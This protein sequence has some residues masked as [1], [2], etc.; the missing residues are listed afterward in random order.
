MDP[1]NIKDRIVDFIRV[2]SSELSPHPLN[3]RTH[4]KSQASA[5]AG[6]LEEIGMAGALIAVKRNGSYQ[7]LDGHLRAE[8]AE[9]Q[10]VPVIVV[11]LN[12]K[13]A[14]KLL[15]TFDTIGRA[16]GIDSGMMAEAASH[17]EFDT[18]A[19]KTL[20]DK[21]IV[22]F[23]DKRQFD[24]DQDEITEPPTPVASR[25][26]VWQCGPHKVA[27]ADSMDAAF[28]DSF[29]DGVDIALM[30]TDPP[31]AVG[32]EFNGYDDT[33]DN[34]KRIIEKAI[35]PLLPRCRVAFVSVGTHTA[36]DYPRP[37]WVLSWFHYG[38]RPGPWGITVHTMIL[39]YG[40]D[41]Y[42]ANGRGL[43][44]DGMAGRTVTDDQGRDFVELHSCPKVLPFWR[45]LMERGSI[46]K[47]DVVFDP[48]LGSGTTLI[49]AEQLERVC[50][51]IELSPTYVDIC[52]NRY[53]ELTGESPVRESDGA[54]FVDLPDA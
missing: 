40:K 52:L 53:V 17:V 30:Q 20:V 31:Y 15:L 14:L 32:Y 1:A 4:P 43:R 22:E 34:L 10:D 19:L 25:G 46:D 51:G 21:T 27:C 28:A 7:I 23:A 3:W 11:D 29:L 37:T 36:W 45:W 16:A 41:P 39:A 18:K 6:A 13:E 38:D 35:T 5:M 42:L 26:D 12:D 48:L 33:L 47:G 8:L 24:V 54:K 50:Y 44:W 49:A 9:G 2:P